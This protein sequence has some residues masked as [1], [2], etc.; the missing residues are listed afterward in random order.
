MSSPDSRGKSLIYEYPKGSKITITCLENKTGGR[1]Y[2]DSYR[3]Y[4]P[5]RYTGKRHQLRQRKTES[6][7]QALADEIFKNHGT[8]GQVAFNLTTSEIIDAGEALKLLKSNGIEKSLTEVVEYASPKLKPKG[9][10]VTVFEAVKQMISSRESMGYRGDGEKDLRNRLRTFSDTFG[11]KHVSDIEKLEVTDWIQGLT[12]Q[13]TNQP[14]SGRSRLNYYRKAVH[15]FNWCKGRDFIETSPLQDLPREQKRELIG[16]SDKKPNKIYSVDE[17]AKLMELTLTDWKF[18]RVTAIWTLGFFTGLRSGELFSASWDDIRVDGDGAEIYV[19][20]QHAKLRGER[21]TTIPPNAL[22]W[23]S[24]CD[25]REGKIYK[26]SRSTYDRDCKALHALAGIPRFDN[27]MRKTC[28]SQ[29]YAYFGKDA[30][31]AMEMG[32]DGSSTTTFHTNYK[33]LVSKA[34]AKQYR[35]IYPPASDSKIVEF[36]S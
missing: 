14:L 12:N 22:K 4:I 3:V 16:R 6:E 5:Q 2:N 34:E 17:V 15:F 29:H 19:S 18:R 21:Y 24:L 10:K 36:A 8:H 9:G 35:C 13:K 32:Q 27:G 11:S 26:Q 30:L 23:L 31:T 25:D 20:P 33:A 7:A 28:G 1:T